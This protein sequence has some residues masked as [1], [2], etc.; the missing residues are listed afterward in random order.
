M[1]ENF[2]IVPF[3]FHKIELHDHN[4]D[5]TKFQ[6]ACLDL[7]LNTCDLKRVGLTTLTSIEVHKESSWHKRLS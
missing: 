2:Y 7:N 6:Q 5:Y 1:R 4:K 3:M